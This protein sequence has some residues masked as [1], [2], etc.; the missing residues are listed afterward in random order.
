MKKII[1]VII[2]LA[3][4]SQPQPYSP[5]PR[6]A[7]EEETWNE[8]PYRLYGKDHGLKAGWMTPFI[9]N[10]A[11]GKPSDCNLD[12]Y[13]KQSAGLPKLREF[14]KYAAKSSNGFDRADCWAMLDIVKDDS[15][16]DRE[17]K[18]LAQV[19]KVTEALQ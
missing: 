18:R 1:L 2:L 9:W 17:R 12:F 16:T 11:A 10:D 13:L 5:K 8:I 14:M 15:D 19:K 3:A 4:C 6:H 7:A